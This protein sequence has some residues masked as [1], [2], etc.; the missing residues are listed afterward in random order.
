MLLIIHHKKDNKQLCPTRR[1][2]SKMR[3]IIALCSFILF[4]IGVYAQSAVI[5]KAWLEHGVT[6]NGV[7]GMKI[8]VNFDAKNMKGKQG[9]VCVY[10]Q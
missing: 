4:T 5:K 8:H 7:K 2:D 3:R 1:R 9:K 6:E 10:F